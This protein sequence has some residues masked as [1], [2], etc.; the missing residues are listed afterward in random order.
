PRHPGKFPYGE[1]RR[2]RI[3]RDYKEERVFSWKETSASLSSCGRQSEFPE[4]RR[5]RTEA[6]PLTPIAQLREWS[7][8]VAPLA[9]ALAAVFALLSSAT[10]RLGFAWRDTELVR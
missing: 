8:E 9:L 7:R 10:R 5:E 3:G 6:I 2:S 4:T 1:S